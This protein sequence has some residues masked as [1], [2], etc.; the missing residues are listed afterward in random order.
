MSTDETLSVD[1]ILR[2]ADS[3]TLA[4]VTSAAVAAFDADI[5]RAVEERTAAIQR[6]AEAEAVRTS[7]HTQVDLD[8]SK[9]ELTLGQL[10][11]DHGQDV[12]T[13]A[14][15]VSVSDQRSRRPELTVSN[16]VTHDPC[17]LT[18]AWR[19]GGTVRASND[20]KY[21]CQGRLY[22]CNLRM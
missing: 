1:D 7:S 17:Y 22:G 10:V 21:I 19:G 16:Y 20:Q 18:V 3:T 8:D 14:H 5:A 4:A 12:W 13:S 9:G 2:P 6:A 15:A 11:D